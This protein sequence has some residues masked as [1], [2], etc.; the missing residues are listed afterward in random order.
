MVGNEVLGRGRGRGDEDSGAG[1]GSREGSRAWG[2]HGAVEE[3]PR[4]T[5]VAEDEVD[6][7]RGGILRSNGLKSSSAS[8]RYHTVDRRRRHIRYCSRGNQLDDESTRR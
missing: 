2:I 7:G 1:E 4:I 3:G 6:M 8:Y 5:E